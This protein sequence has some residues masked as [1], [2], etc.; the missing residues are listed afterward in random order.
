MVI[1]IMHKVDGS[2]QY[3]LIASQYL[4]SD[5]FTQKIKFFVTTVMSSEM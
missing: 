4:H 2:W 5:F 1:K 3:G